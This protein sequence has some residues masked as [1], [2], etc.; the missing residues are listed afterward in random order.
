MESEKYRYVTCPGDRVRFRWHANGADARSLGG[1]YKFQRPM[2]RRSY[3]K[4]SEFRTGGS[5]GTPV[6]SHPPGHATH[7][8]TCKCRIQ[9][10]RILS[11][12][13]LSCDD[14]V[15]GIIVLGSTRASI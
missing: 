15:S 11:E 10:L 6:G 13:S 14:G 3:L 9:G 2:A 8:V 1:R 5:L 12:Q 4:T 7:H